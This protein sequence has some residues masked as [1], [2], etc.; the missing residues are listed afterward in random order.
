MNADSVIAAR[1]TPG[2][3]A[4]IATI[5][6]R[7]LRASA[8]VLELTNLKA[9]SLKLNQIHYGTFRIRKSGSESN[10]AEE[11]VVVC[12]TREDV[13]ELH[14]HGGVAVSRA[15][16][17]AVETAGA[18]IV[19][20]AEFLGGLAGNPSEANVASQ[21]LQAKTDRVASHLIDQLNGSFRVRVQ[22]LLRRVEASIA[23]ADRDEMETL[24]RE[25]R[26]MLDLGERFA[27]KWI[28]GWSI[29]LAGPPNVGKSSLMN[30]IVG[31]QKSIVHHE[32]GTT[33]DWVE[34]QTVIAGWPVRLSDTAGIRAASEEIEAAGVEFSVAQVEQA[35]LLLLVVDSTSGWSDTHSR[36]CELSACPVIVCW[37]K[38]DLNPSVPNLEI[39]YPV[40]PLSCKGEA[41][42]G[43]E[44]LE[45]LLNSI[46]GELFHDAPTE[47]EAIPIAEDERRKLNAALECLEAEKPS[48]AADVF[49]ALLSQTT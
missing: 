8:L 38:I 33:R 27:A 20:S 16:L 17:E 24:S 1:L 30:R 37:N 44:G 15:I 42:V 47:N 48:E 41:G 32:A 40:V 25:V 26:R 21:L 5:G 18:E 22:E 23:T 35:D 31:Q 34:A 7:G 13:V 43:T 10:V 45:G 9:K 6:L 14:C 29:V 49:R 46:S 39:G 4:G 3:P 12:R 36:L 19:D 28:E 11:T 2:V